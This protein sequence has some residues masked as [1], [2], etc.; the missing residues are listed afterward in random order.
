M[1]K[2]IH[3]EKNIEAEAITKLSD[4]LDSIP[5]IELL[6]VDQQSQNDNMGVDFSVEVDISGKRHTLICQVKSSG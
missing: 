2:T 1:L 6:S 5:T 4:L 3:H